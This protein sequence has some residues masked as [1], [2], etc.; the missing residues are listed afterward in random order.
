MC[1]YVEVVNDVILTRYELNDGDLRDIGK[2]TRENIAVWLSNRKTPDP[3]ESPPVRDFH[4]V[5]G[6]IDIPWT[7]E[8]AEKRFN[9]HR[10]NF[11]YPPAVPTRS[12]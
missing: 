12:R 11:G 1:A 10:L 8:G 7:T 6:E 3:F 5:S 4:A 2:F 9:V